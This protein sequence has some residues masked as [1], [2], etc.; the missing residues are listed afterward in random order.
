[1]CQQRLPPLLLLADEA[2]LWNVLQSSNSPAHLL[3][4][5]QLQ[6]NSEEESG[7]KNRVKSE[8]S[9]RHSS[10]GG[11][12]SDGYLQ[13]MAACLCTVKHL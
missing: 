6:T 5:V 8:V 3:R 1:M 11:G 9:S 7:K 12:A 13:H 4:P 2:S 10:T